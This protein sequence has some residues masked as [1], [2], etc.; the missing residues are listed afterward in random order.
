MTTNLKT[1]CP[2]CGKR[3]RISESKRG[4][5]VRCPACREAFVAS[6]VTEASQMTI[7]TTEAAVSVDTTQLVKDQTLS[8]L[9]SPAAKNCEE[10]TLRKLGRFELKS[11]LGAGGFG[12]V[13]RAYDPQLERFVALKVPTFG[14]NQKT[15]IARFLAEAK[16]AARLKHAN[17]V[18]TFESGKADK[19]HYIASEYIE[20]HLLSALAKR[21]RYSVKDAAQIVRK[22]AEA[23]AYAHSQGIVHRDIKP[24]NVMVD[25]AGEPQLMDFGLAKRTDDSSNL[26]TDGAL[27]GTP[28]YMSPEQARGELQLVN[29]S[30]DQYSLGVVLYHLLTGATPSEGSPHIVISEVAKGEFHSVRDRDTTIDRTLDAICQ[31]AMHPE[32]AQRYTDCNQFA[33][34]LDAWVNK[35]PVLARPLTR[36]QQLAR[37]LAEHQLMIILFS[38]IMVLSALVAVFAFRSAKSRVGTETADF[39]SNASDDES[40]K[41]TEAIT[42][43]PADPLN[44]GNDTTAQQD[45]SPRVSKDSPED[46]LLTTSDIGFM[47]LIDSQGEYEWSEPEPMDELGRPK[48]DRGPSISMDGLTLAFVSKRPTGT[49]PNHLWISR[50]P[51]IDSA[52]SAPENPGE[53]LNHPAGSWSPASFRA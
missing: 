9:V 32:Q 22:L 20:G 26:T 6:D 19:K 23:V 5:T 38:M 21:E 14:P 37:T 4:K 35:K 12:K 33:A 44:A 16:A 17:I 52:W 34:D 2:S 53:P 41:P 7:D 50:R 18:S 48:A 1:A 27:L 47:A 3:L 36:L 39:D 8:D 49:G 13:Y 24:H 10:K 25:S 31:K 46:H 43:P 15:R 51:S 40:A 42:Q 11:V 30:S 29:E 28:A 45:A